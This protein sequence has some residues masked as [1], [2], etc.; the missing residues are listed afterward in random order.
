MRRLRLTRS[1]IDELARWRSR[2][3]AE[4]VQRDVESCARCARLEAQL[5]ALTAELAAA[6]VHGERVVVVWQESK[7][8][9]GDR[10]AAFVNSLVASLRD[11]PAVWAFIG[12]VVGGV[13]ATIVRY[14]AILWMAV[15]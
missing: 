12:I 3:R 11:H 5:A 15:G 10:V 4:R 13:L 6:R 7:A 9:P 2:R 14:T 1:S 8:P